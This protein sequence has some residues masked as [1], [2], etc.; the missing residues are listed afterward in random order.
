MAAAVRTIISVDPGR[1]K[2]GVAVVCS[3]ADRAVKVL[4][5]SVI[6][7]GQL[8]DILADLAREHEPDIVLIGNGTGSESAR[9]VVEELAV[10]PVM[11]VDEKDTSVLARKRYFVEKP[12]RGLRRLIP[13]SLQTPP[14]PYDDLVAVIFAE[15]HLLH[16]EK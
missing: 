7:T 9:E 16:S 10:A 13:T 6:E 3:D 12:P 5:R 14:E 8:R 2:C 11:E 15:R 4:H 1:F